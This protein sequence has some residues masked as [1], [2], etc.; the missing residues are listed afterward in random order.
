[1]VAIITVTT[2]TSGTFS[3]TVT[4]TSTSINTPGPTTMGFWFVPMMFMLLGIAGTTRIGAGYGKA[5]QTHLEG[6][7]FAFLVML[8]LCLGSWFGTLANITPLGLSLLFSAVVVVMVWR[9]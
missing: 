8:G 2:T 3:T 5:S 1:T 9:R 6:S 7:T 4:V